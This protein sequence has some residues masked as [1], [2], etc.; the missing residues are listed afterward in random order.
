MTGVQT[1][2]LPICFPVTI[3]ELR[4]KQDQVCGQMRTTY[5]YWHL[6]RQ[7]N[8]LAPPTLDDD[9]VRCTVRKDIFAAPTE[10]GLIVSFGNI[11]KV[12][13]PLPITAEPGLLDHV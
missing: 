5:D 8:P 3:G 6:G 1:C 12:V 13:R 11:L 2:A 4:T 7:F 9:F 10:P